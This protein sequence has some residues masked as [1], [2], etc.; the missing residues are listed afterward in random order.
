MLMEVYRYLL[1][2]NQDDQYFKSKP[3]ILH[4][5]EFDPSLEPNEKFTRYIEKTCK[6]ISKYDLLILYVL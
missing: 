3:F 6:R 1:K 5:Y 2:I 4:L